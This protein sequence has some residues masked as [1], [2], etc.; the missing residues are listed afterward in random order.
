MSKRLGNTVSPFDIIK[1]HGADSVRWYMITNSQPWENLKFD[2]AGIIEIKQ[3]FFSTLYNVY[4]FFSL[5][6]LY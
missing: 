1:K 5:Y 3:K 4:S 2:V 6:R